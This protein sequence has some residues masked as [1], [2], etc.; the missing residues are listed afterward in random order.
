MLVE[1]VKVGPDGTIFAL[2]KIGFLFTLLRMRIIRPVVRA[3][4]SRYR[5]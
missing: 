2:L 5:P 4:P 1:N 3:R